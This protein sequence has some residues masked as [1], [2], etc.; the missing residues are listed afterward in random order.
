VVI[1]AYTDS[2]VCHTYSYFS[3]GFS[4]SEELALD[5]DERVFRA[6]LQ[7]IALQVKEYLLQPHLVG[8]NV[9]APIE[10]FEI[11]LNFDIHK[12]GFVF[13]NHYYF[14]DCL[15]EIKLTNFF[16]ELLGV[17]LSNREHVVDREAHD[18]S[19]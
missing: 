14:F 19:R 13:L 15:L 2:L 4:E 1:W 12:L 5:L 3:V 9:L 17:E 16:P 10:S 8:A 6:K 11:G 7:C 18:L